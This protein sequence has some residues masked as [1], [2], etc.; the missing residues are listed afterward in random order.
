MHAR[1][2]EGER[3]GGREGGE[4]ERK[5]ERERQTDRQRQRV[6]ERRRERQRETEREIEDRV[7]DE[8][9]ISSA[10]TAL[11]DQLHDISVHDS[12]LVIKSPLEERAELSRTEREREKMR[13]R[14]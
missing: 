12:S 6:R 10:R 4:R 5:K 7:H 14:K 3:W 9:S 8:L 2:R 11:L 13:E 1:V